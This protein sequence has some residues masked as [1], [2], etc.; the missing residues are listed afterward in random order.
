MRLLL[1]IIGIASLLW[2][3]YWFLGAQATEQGLALWL[4]DRRSDGW[5]AD[6]SSI[7]TRGF[8]NR[9]DTTLHGL[10]LAD[11]ATGVAWTTPFLQI[12][13]LSYKPNHVI[14]AFPEAHSVSTPY[15]TIEILSKGT[16][17]SLVLQP[18][19]KL[20][21]DRSSFVTDDLNL[22]S[23]MGWT[24]AA[25]QLRFATRV[26]PSQDNAYDLAIG[27]V[28]VVPGG[29]WSSIARNA[30]LPGE[31][32]DL[33]LDMTVGF[34]APWDR[35]AIEK[36]R[37]QPRAIN[38][39][40]L[41]AEWG[42]LLFQA[43]GELTVDQDGV[44]TGSV[45]IQAQNWQEMM[46]LGVSTGAIPQSAVPSLQGMLSLLAGLSGNARHID[47]TLNFKNGFMAV[48]PVPIAPAPILKIR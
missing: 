13:S 3:G 22:K 23:T 5:Q 15:E 45:A 19:T 6:A 1:S 12:L 30:N 41:K 31:I 4:D 14:A 9:F 27:G 39:K 29:I 17:G 36:T 20:A 38:L 35:L 44:P 18:N 37:P 34:D 21:L 26:N 46:Q 24:L 2:G 28:G 47:A 16:R 25:R 8:P 33:S 42:E 40:I 10:R 11:P 7:E 48:G 32:G 43:K